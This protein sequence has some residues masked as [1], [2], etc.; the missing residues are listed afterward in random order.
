MIQDGRTGRN[1]RHEITGL[2]RQSIYARLSGYED[3]NDQELLLRE[4]AMR[5]VI[6]KRAL[7]RNAASPQT[8]SRFE[9]EILPTEE[10]IQAL[11]ELNHA[12]V[13][14]AMQAAKPRRS[15]WTWT[16][17]SRRYRETRRAPPETGTSA[18]ASTTRY[19]SSTRQATAKG[20][21]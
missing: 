1:I 6:G 11:A 3:V 2:L 10:N 8:V 12:R 16:H 21:P 19:S 13:A 9:T 17:P 18:P 7:E 15:S 20:I 14:R 4:S 5:A